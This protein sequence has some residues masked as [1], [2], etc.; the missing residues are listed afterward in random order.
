MQV[1]PVR[2]WCIHFNY[3][4][5]IRY[6]AFVAGAFFDLVVCTWFPVSARDFPI[7]THIS[8]ALSFACWMYL[9]AHMYFEGE[10]NS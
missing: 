9:D 6:G 7:K 10:G 4:Y 3:V 5:I 1:C 2:K 8:G